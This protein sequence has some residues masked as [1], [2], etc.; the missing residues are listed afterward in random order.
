MGGIQPQKVQALTGA[1]LV[2]K[3]SIFNSL[4]GLSNRFI[5]G[6]FED[7]YLC[8][9]LHNLGLSC[10]LVPEVKLIHAERQSFLGR[11]PKDGDS[12]WRV[13]ANAWLAQHST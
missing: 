6:D 12:L 9:Q 5:R 4:G 3:R 10:L 11:E 1:V 2:I 13:L 8:E 7:S